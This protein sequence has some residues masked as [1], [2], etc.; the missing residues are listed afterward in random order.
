MLF[1]RG[2]LLIPWP[3][4]MIVRSRFSTDRKGGLAVEGYPF[5][6]DWQYYFSASVRSYL[7]KISDEAIFEMNKC[8]AEA[9]VLCDFRPGAFGVMLDNMNASRFPK[10]NN[11]YYFT[12]EEYAQGYLAAAIAAGRA[13]KGRDFVFQVCPNQDEN[14]Q[15]GEE[16]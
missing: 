7:N 9:N 11:R 15:K 1:E 14:N 13:K 4:N 16:S 2:K 12:R 6:V 10:L 8:L 3:E 5:D